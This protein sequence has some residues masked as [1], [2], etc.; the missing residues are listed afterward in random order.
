MNKRQVT[1]QDL[2]AKLKISVSTVSRALK[3]HPRISR[4]TKEAV[5]Q[6]AKDL[7]YEPNQLALGLKNKHINAIGVVV[8]KITYHLYA[9]AISGIENYANAKGYNIMICQSNESMEREKAI[10][11]ELIA[12]R[13]AGFI[14]SLSSETD[15]FDHF[16]RLQK[17]GIPLVFFNR[18][19][20]DVQA[21]RVIIDNFQAAYDA[22]DHL[23]GTGCKK[24]AYIGGPREVQISNH[25]M[26]GYRQALTDN[27]L[28]VDGR[29]ILH[30]E[31]NRQSALSQARKLVYGPEPPEA[32]LAFSDQIAISAIK[33]CKERGLKI[34]ENISIIGFNNEPVTELLEPPLTSVDQPGFL[35]G[36][37]AA[38]LLVRQIESEGII[39]KPEKRILNASLIIRKSTNRNRL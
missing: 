22:V 7:D 18:E 33:A 2:A 15:N 6:L 9:T 8:P 12:S 11:N 13:V 30:C 3:D 34:P 39:D 35:M 32:I 10:I 37:S 1:L 36:K 20:Q 27:H 5:W 23:I 4:K 26:E 16:I 25:R 17:K 21:D 19:C 31:F 29:L 28:E 38:E 24:I 14:I